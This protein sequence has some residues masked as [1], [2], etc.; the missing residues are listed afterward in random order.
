MT[1][2]NEVNSECQEYQPFYTKDDYTLASESSIVSESSPARKKQR[3]VMDAYLLNNKT[4]HKMRRGG[5]SPDEKVGVYSTNTTPGTLIKD[6][7]TGGT[8]DICRVGTIYEDLF[9]KVG[10]ATGEFGSEPKTMFFD[11][12]EQ[13]ERHLNETVSQ[14]TKDKWTTKFAFTRKLLEDGE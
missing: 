13:Y 8:S 12:P 10:F 3:S 6:A 11:C 1:D 5:G 14:P 4:Y 2:D 7:V 9:F